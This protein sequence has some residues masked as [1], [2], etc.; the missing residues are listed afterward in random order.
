MSH[1]GDAEL[2][3]GFLKCLLGGLDRADLLL[4]EG[5]QG[6]DELL[7][8]LDQDPLHLL[9]H[10]GEELGELLEGASDEDLIVSQ[11]GPEAVK[12]AAEESKK[13]EIRR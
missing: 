6:A 13:D 2:G 4:P 11:G 3:G 9:L 8:G 12:L 5:E 1:L 10:G 7:L